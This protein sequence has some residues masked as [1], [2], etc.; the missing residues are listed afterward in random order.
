ML[1]V[2]FTLNKMSH[3]NRS[4][5]F[6]YLQDK[7]THYRQLRNVKPVVLSRGRL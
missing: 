5:L 3:V 2:I 6:T 4:E 1:L 7:A